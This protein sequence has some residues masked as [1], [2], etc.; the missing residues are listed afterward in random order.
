MKLTRQIVLIL[1]SAAIALGSFSPL[2]NAQENLS[3]NLNTATATEI[4]Y[5]IDGVGEVRAEAI[6]ALR[7]KL[8]GY[9]KLEQL[10]EINGIGEATLER[11]RSIIVLE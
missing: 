11:I 2:A 3:I 8:G 1:V 4:A 5:A 7:D 10:L 9:T 6:V